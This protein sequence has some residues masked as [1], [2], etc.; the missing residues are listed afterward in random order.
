MIKLLSKQQ[1]PINS[2]ASSQ[3][4]KPLLDPQLVKDDNEK[5]GVTVF[6]T[7]LGIQHDR[8]ADFLD[9]CDDESDQIN[10]TIVQSEVNT[11]GHGEQLASLLLRNAD[12]YISRVSMRQSIVQLFIDR[13]AKL[14]MKYKEPFG[15][16]NSW[17]YF[18]LV[19]RT[20][21]NGIKTFR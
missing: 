10:A 15:K 13:L 8:L 21:I 14:S 17:N 18:D 20:L 4:F 11:G 3:I 19:A 1:I 7:L 16:D 2:V 12:K 6:S 5:K 9:W